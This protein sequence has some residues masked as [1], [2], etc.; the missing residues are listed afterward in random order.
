MIEVLAVL[1]LIIDFFISATILLHIAGEEDTHLGGLLL[2][3]LLLAN[4]FLLLYLLLNG[5]SR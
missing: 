5:G 1:V 4:G 3:V 2:G